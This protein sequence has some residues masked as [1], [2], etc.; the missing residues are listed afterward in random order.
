MRPQWIMRFT[1]LYLRR[2]SLPILFVVLRWCSTFS[3]YLC[4]F[5]SCLF[6]LDFSPPQQIALSKHCICSTVHMVS[7]L[8][9]VEMLVYADIS[10]VF[11]RMFLSSD[12]TRRFRLISRSKC[13]LIALL[14]SCHV[15]KVNESNW[16]GTWIRCFMVDKQSLDFSFSP[17]LL[18]FD[19]SFTFANNSRT[20]LCGNKA[21]R[22]L[23]CI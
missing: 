1:S 3:D 16:R 5:C 4:Q 12:W 17:C 20:G 14:L 21:K 6:S 7:E 11:D 18:Y 23:L 15:S 22:L 2:G 19:I 10:E 9:G 13:E 8:I